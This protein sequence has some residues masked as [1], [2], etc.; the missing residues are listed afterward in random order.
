MKVGIIG[1]GAVGSACLLSMVMRG[2]AREVVLVNRD[3][4]R[5]Q[6]VVTDVQ[7]GAVLSPPIT[8]RD[9]DYSDLAGSSVVMITAGVN[10]KA[11][12]ATD[13]SDP[14]G[15]LRLLEANAAIFQDIV[16]QIH[17]SAPDA[18]IL[19]VTDPPDALADVVR[20]LGH[21]RVLSTG[22]SLD[23]LRFRFHLGKRL[24]VSASDVEAVVLGEHGTSSVFLWSSA[25]VGG[26][27][28]LDLLGES[29]TAQTVREE[30]EREVRYANITVIEGIGAS[31]YGIGMVSARLTEMVLRD[32]RAVIPIGCYNPTFG[33]TLSLPSVVGREGVHRLIEPEMSAAE[34]QGLQS[35]AEAIKAAL[36][37]LSLKESRRRTA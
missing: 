14:V 8:V 37:R 11:G 24:N 19:V 16:P 23:T 22:T 36:S 1:A 34:Q 6:G 5:A 26:K 29:Q 35:S 25:R 32:E 4:K 31:Q 3:R 27:K 12:G 17:Y 20:M 28:V 33:V 9:G 21:E 15:R 30:L 10:E 13:R 2:S 7:H 18:L